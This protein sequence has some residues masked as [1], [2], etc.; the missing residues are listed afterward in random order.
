MLEL[1][2]AVALVTGAGSG[3]GRA[4]A[5]EAAARGMDVAVCDIAAGPAEATAEAV[6]AQGRR[7]IAVACDVSDRAAVEAMAAR[8]AAELA[9]VAL[10][11][12]N[13]GVTSFEA[14]A[15]IDPAELE[16]VLDVNLK[17]AA[18][19]MRAVLPQMIAAGRGHV[20]ATASMAGLIPNW[21]SHHVPYVASKAGLIG[22]IVNLRAELAPHG[23]GAT[24]LCPAGVTTD[25]L[26]AR[27]RRPQRFGGPSA[28]PIT[29]PKSFRSTGGPPLTS[30]TPE[31]VA[32]M[33]FEAVLADRPL[34]VTE[35][36]LR[37]LF[38]AHA[39]VVLQAF[40]DAAE[41]ERRAGLAE[42]PADA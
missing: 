35:S 34:V 5:L 15:D 24:A 20:V 32:R 29:P 19:C 13:A 12:A 36:R 30:R 42:P 38:E 39:E 1:E 26:N 28:A 14:L 31:M 2:G 7:A 3:I 23:V 16:W 41:F 17:G 4:F 21:V 6:R 9:P 27:Q 22:W 40:G 37:G 8:T 33:T 10:L 11:F 18:W 25:I